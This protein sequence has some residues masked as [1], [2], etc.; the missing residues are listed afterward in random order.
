MTKRH[1]EAMAGLVFGVAITVFIHAHVPIQSAIITPIPTPAIPASNPIYTPIPALNTRP[2]PSTLPHI[3]HAHVTAVHDGDTV[4]IRIQEP[5]DPR[6]NS[7]L[8]VRLWGIDA[9]ELKQ[10]FG[11]Q[12][13]EAMEKMVMNKDV[14]IVSHGVER[15]GRT[16]GEITVS[17]YN[18]DAHPGTH[19]DSA[20]LKLVRMGLAWWYRKFSPGAVEYRQAEQRAREDRVGLWAGDSPV[21]PWDFRHPRHI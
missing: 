2:V 17:G 8:R 15:Y 5:H 3:L 6:D 14:E 1:T 9:P 20:N 4:T 13:Q 11:A 7:I 18:P 19:P 12:A 21:A 10:D 16:L